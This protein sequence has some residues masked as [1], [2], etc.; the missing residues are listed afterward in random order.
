MSAPR[1]AILTIA[2]LLL[3]GCIAPAS[4][5]GSSTSAPS[6]VNTTPV[7]HSYDDGHTDQQADGSNPAFWIL[8][9]A[10]SCLVVIAVIML[11]AGRAPRALLSRGAP[12]PP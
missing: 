8:A 2:I 5:S 12:P 11:R 7:T 10:V 1:A 4:A 3:I 6:P 9:I